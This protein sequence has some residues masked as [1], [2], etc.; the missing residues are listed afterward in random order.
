MV[1]GQELL[2]LTGDTGAIH[3]LAFSG[4]GHSLFTADAP[5]GN[6]RFEAH[7]TYGVRVWDAAPLTGEAASLRGRPAP[8]RLPDNERPAR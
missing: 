5:V 2:T 6:A 3:G 1:S 8:D 7:R 4:D